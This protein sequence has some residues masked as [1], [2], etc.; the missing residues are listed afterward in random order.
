MRYR[1]RRC[2]CEACAVEA[3]YVMCPCRAKTLPCEKVDLADI[4]ETG[5]HVTEMRFAPK[6]RLTEDMKVFA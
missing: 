5:K 3:P 4:L 6:P 2:S 1:R